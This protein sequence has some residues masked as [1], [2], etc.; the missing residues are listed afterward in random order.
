MD[1]KTF[2]GLPKWLISCPKKC[3]RSYKHRRY[4]VGINHADAKAVQATALNHLTHFTELR[5]TYLWQK[6]E[7]PKRLSAFPQRSKSKFSDNERMNRNL[8]TVKVSVHRFVY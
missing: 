4:Q 5:H 2:G 1:A 8:P 3:R 6:I 7:Q